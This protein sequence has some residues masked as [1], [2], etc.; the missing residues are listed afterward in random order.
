MEVAGKRVE[1]AESKKGGDYEHHPVDAKWSWSSRED[2][3]HTPKPDGAYRV[4]SNTGGHES[5]SPALTRFAMRTPPGSTPSG[6]R[7][8]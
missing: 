8:N 2:S 5:V 7:K 4:G 1:F 3:R 6:P